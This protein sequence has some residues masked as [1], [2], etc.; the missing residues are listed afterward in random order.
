M[1]SDLDDYKIDIKNLHLIA[2]IG[3]N[4]NGNL[5]IA[6]DLIMNA[7]DAGFHSV[8]FQ[9]RTI[10]AVY[11]KEQLEKPRESPWGKTPGNR[12]R[13]LNFRERNMM[14]LMNFVMK[15]KLIGL[16]QLGI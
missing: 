5:N 1:P 3:I 12:K 10:E 13:V 7:K 2:E 9:K 16:R 8:K 6:K 11:S 14:K 4:H 15:K